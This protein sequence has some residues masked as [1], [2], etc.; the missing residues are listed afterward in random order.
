MIEDL[1]NNPIE[2]PLLIIPEAE[3]PTILEEINS[4]KVKVPRL[5]NL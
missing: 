2:I 1:K 4:N 3:N 5:L